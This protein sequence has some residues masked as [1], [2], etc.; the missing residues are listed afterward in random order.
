MKSETSD[1]LEKGER[2][3][4]VA[5]E[6]GD[7]H[8]IGSTGEVLDRVGPMPEGAPFAGEYGY[9]VKFDGDPRAPIFIRGAKIA[10]EEEANVH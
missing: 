5:G 6:P 10:K 7:G 1:V 8:D 3:K 4:K 9:F 2:F